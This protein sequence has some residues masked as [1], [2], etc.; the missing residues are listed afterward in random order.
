MD[1]KLNFSAKNSHISHQETINFL[2]RIDEKLNIQQL[3]N[4][5]TVC[6]DFDETLSNI[7]VYKKY[8]SDI[9]KLRKNLSKDIRSI[10]ADL[11]GISRLLYNLYTNGKKIWIVSFGVSELIQLCMAVIANYIHD[12]INNK[13]T[14]IQIFRRF[15]ILTPKFFAKVRNNVVPIDVHINDAKLK[16][17]YFTQYPDGVKLLNQK[18]DML[19]YIINI[20]KLK[21]DNLL[22]IDNDKTNVDAG[23]KIG[24]FGLHVLDNNGLSNNDIRCLNYYLANQQ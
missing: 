11:D 15:N 2:K 8:K 12:K 1:K 7:H 4:I 19:K 16:Y 10:F 22:F 3:K 5:T 13:E 17:K 9:E 18:N 20:E 23:R 6:F 24:V 14:A 21:K